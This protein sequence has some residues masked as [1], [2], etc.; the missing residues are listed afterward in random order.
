VS[1]NSHDCFMCLYF[2]IIH[3]FFQQKGHGANKIICNHPLSLS[4]KIREGGT[5]KKMDEYK[6]IKQLAKE[7]RKNQTGTEEML[8]QKLRNRKLYGYKFL[9]QHPIIHSGFINKLYFFI[10]DFYCAEK[11]LVIE[12]DGKIHENQYTHP[13]VPSLFIESGWG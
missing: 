2:V 3:L 4:L 12:L 13:F 9:R 11:E 6:T 5:K 8:W 7:L 10:A 1:L